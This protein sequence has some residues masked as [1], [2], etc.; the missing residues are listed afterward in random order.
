M[1][2]SFTSDLDFPFLEQSIHS[3]HSSSLQDLNSLSF[4]LSSMK[5]F[6]ESLSFTNPDLTVENSRMTPPPT[7]QTPESSKLAS[8]SKPGRKHSKS[9]YFSPEIPQIQAQVSELKILVEGLVNRI[10]NCNQN[11]QNHIIKS[12]TA[13]IQRNSVIE[14]GSSWKKTKERTE[15]RFFSN[16]GENTGIYLSKVMKIQI[17]K[18]GQQEMMMPLLACSVVNWIGS[19]RVLD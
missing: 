6:R 5:S 10:V 11:L 16:I 9:C 8:S 2:I 13:K 7:Y 17:K 18:V 3:I 4:L 15:N 14:K 12:Q 1:S 19:L